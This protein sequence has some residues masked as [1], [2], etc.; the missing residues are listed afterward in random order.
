M[1][2]LADTD[3]L[4]EQVFRLRYEVYSRELGWEDPANFPD[5]LE[6]D[7]FDS[8]SLHCLIHHR[9]TGAL[10]GTVRLVLPDPQEPYAPF[11][12]ELTC[13][14]RLHGEF[15]DPRAIDRRRACE[16]SRLAVVSTFRRRPGERDREAPLLES[17]NGRETERRAMPYLS[18]G[19]YLAG[20]SM[21]LL[22]GLETAFA[23]MEPRLLRRLAQ[24]GVVFERIGEELEHRGARVPCRATREM[25]FSNM[26]P[27]VASLLGTIRED[28]AK[29]RYWQQDPARTADTVD[30]A[31]N[32]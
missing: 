19:L 18:L 7:S 26:S 3:E 2:L 25:L 5:G 29:S 30:T 20:A 6:R 4:R 16:I 22:S 1:I 8:R 9:P 23:I 15:S 24:Y 28:L 17:A 27:E 32:R 21:A 31:L 11:P 10:A 14:G 12:F 13:R